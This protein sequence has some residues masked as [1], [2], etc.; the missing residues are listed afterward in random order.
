MI[1]IAINNQIYL[2]IVLGECDM[3][4]KE[5]A[6]SRFEIKAIRYR[7]ATSSWPSWK[8]SD[9]ADTPLLPSASRPLF[10]NQKSA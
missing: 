2:K 4:L 10:C 5:K 7:P 3:R 1:G 6:L 8:A 9:Y